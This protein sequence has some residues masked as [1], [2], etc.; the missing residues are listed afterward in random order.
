M[1]T[2]WPATATLAVNSQ[3]AAAVTATDA[4]GAS[5]GISCA[6]IVGA[7]QSVHAIANLKPSTGIQTRATQQF[8]IMQTTLAMQD[9]AIPV[10][11]WLLA[12][13]AASSCNEKNRTDDVITDVVE[14]A[15]LALDEI[16]A[17]RRVPLHRPDDDQMLE[18]IRAVSVARTAAGLDA[19]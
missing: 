15:T 12:F 8:S 16:F 4:A 11:G 10:M 1:T 19:L 17:L 18:L 2:A 13:L 14:I 5:L 9:D 3:N 6:A 7:A